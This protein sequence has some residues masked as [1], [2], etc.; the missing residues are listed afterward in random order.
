MYGNGD[1]TS[2]RVP[3]FLPGLPRFG[4]VSNLA[5]ASYRAHEALGTL[6][7]ML[8]EV[9]RDS[10]KIRGGLLGPPEFH[11]RRN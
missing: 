8:E 2:S 5:G 1:M 4:K 7:C 9:G 11:Q 3:S 6:R 10:F